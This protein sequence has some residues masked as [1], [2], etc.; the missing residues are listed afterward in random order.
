[1]AFMEKVKESL[2]K[3]AAASRSLA[4]KA[5]RKAAELGSMGVLKIESVEMKSRLEGLMAKLGNQVYESLIEKKHATVSADTRSVR[6]TLNDIG[7]L[8]SNIAKK[9][10]EYKSIGSN[11]KAAI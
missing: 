4:N 11:A 1:M 2:K 6:S 5:G 7:A 3:G 8:R 10:K 9:E